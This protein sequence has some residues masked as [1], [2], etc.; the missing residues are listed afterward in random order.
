MSGTLCGSASYDRP[1]TDKLAV[2][3]EIAGEVTKTL[4]DLLN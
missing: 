3:A 4:Q 1:F 2:Q